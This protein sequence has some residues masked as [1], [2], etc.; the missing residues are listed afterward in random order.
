ML[1]FSCAFFTPL[2]Q[3]HFGR[4]AADKFVFTDWETTHHL[5]PSWFNGLGRVDPTSPAATLGASWLHQGRGWVG[6]TNGCAVVPVCLQ[7]SST[8]SCPAMAP[9]PPPPCVS[10][11]PW[12]A[13]V[14]GCDERRGQRQ[15]GR[16]CRVRGRPKG[17]G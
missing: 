14:G 16:G 8:P 5:P 2:A 3:T 10:R 12:C 9:P 7:R 15:A 13:G 11:R 1:F 4:P 17:E 6:Q